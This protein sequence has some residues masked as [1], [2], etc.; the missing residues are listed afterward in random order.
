L[1]QEIITDGKKAASMVRPVPNSV[2][3]PVSSLWSPTADDPPSNLNLKIMKV[4]SLNPVE[5]AYQVSML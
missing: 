5:E 4:K 2:A 3:L 1:T